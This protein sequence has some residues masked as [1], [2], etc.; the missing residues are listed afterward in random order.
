MNIWAVWPTVHV[1]Q[2]NKMIEEWK[3]QGYK[4]GILVNPPY[5]ERSFPNADKVIVQEQWQ[6]FPTAVNL[7]C[8]SIPGDIM[9]VV[10]DD[11][12]PDP[13]HSAQEIGE[14]FKESFPDLQ[15]VMQPTGDHFAH[16]HLCAVSPWI[17]R[18]FITSAYGGKGPFWE[19]YFHYFSDEEL[20]Q[21]A[22]SQ[23]VFLQYPDI[24]QYH[25]HWQR[26]DRPTRPIHLMK[27]KDLW[28]KDR[29]LFHKRKARGFP[30][31]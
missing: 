3:G 23:S 4:V 16:T 13:D 26:K 6:G 25:D 8:R 7:L 15:G 10:G 24:I 9:V 28:K 1:D 22:L 14:R 11:V 18:G 19:E 27:A 21:Y 5:Q 20:Q 17:G 29:D 30:W 12:Y 2:S 31:D